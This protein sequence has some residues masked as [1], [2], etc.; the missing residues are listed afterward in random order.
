MVLVAVA[1]SREDRDLR[2]WF[3]IASGDHFRSLPYVTEKPVDMHCAQRHSY[4]VVFVDH[5]AGVDYGEVG[6]EVCH[7]CLRLRPDEHVLGEVVLPSQLCDDS[8]VLARLGIRPTV[9]IEYVPVTRYTL[10][11]M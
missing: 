6:L 3:P 9:S 5:L 11:Y 8:H 4:L 10:R 1:G 2:F 7:L